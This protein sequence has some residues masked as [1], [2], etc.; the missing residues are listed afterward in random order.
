MVPLADNDDTAGADRDG[1]RVSVTKDAAG[2]L[3][4]VQDVDN[5][6]PTVPH[7]TQEGSSQGSKRPIADNGG[8]D[9]VDDG[10]VPRETASLIVDAG[11]TIEENGDNHGPYLSPSDV[12]MIVDESKDVSTLIDTGTR[13]ISILD[14]TPAISDEHGTKDDVETYDDEN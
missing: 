14:G 11:N 2:D 13:G 4:L 6:Q 9:G 3:F 7:Q 8:M 10:H 1:L 5:E 12:V